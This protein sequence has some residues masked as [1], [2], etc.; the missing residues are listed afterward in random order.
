MKAKSNA[1][2]KFKEY[3]TDMKIPGRKVECLGFR[4]GLG[5]GLGLEAWNPMEIPRLPWQPSMW[6]SFTL[7]ED[8]QNR[9]SEVSKAYYE[10]GSKNDRKMA[11]LTKCTP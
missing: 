11:G 5:L 2:E 7:G 3:I 9:F 4:V 10:K 1:L 6:P 8:A